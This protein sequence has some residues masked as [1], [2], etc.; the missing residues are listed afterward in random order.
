MICED[1]RKITEPVS[2]LFVVEG[3]QGWCKSTRDNRTKFTATTSL[4][5]RYNS[6]YILKPDYST[7]ENS[8]KAECSCC[9]FFIR[10]IPKA[11]LRSTSSLKSP[12]ICLA[13]IHELNME[14]GKVPDRIAR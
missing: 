10:G 13:R 6:H 14:R 7:L 3:D 9:E 1:C 11:K 8:A 12:E 5:A 2:G 4:F